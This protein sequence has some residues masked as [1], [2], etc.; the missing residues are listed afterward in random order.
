M[1]A[2]ARCSFYFSVGRGSP[3]IPIRIPPPHRVVGF[4]QGC[5]GPHTS[6]TVVY[7]LTTGSCFGY[8]IYRRLADAVTSNLSASGSTATVAALGVH[9]SL[10]LGSWNTLSRCTP[11][12]Y[13]SIPYAPSPL[14]AKSISL[15]S[16]Y[17]TPLHC[18]L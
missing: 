8:P 11:D 4:F 6:S 14:T 5:A 1:Y 9:T 12:S 13:F 16:A 15:R 18:T 7:V 3:Y 2:G 10:C 17:G